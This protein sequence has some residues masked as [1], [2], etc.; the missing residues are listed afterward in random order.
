[1]KT[2]LSALILLVFSANPLIAQ[3]SDLSDLSDYKWQDRV[4]LIF[5]PNTYNSDYRA[6]VDALQNIS[7]G[8]KERD[9]KIFYALEQSSASV[10]GAL[11]SEDAID[12][13]RSDFNISSSDF[14]VLLIGKDGN[15]KYRS[16]EFISSKKLFNEIDS[17]PMRK[18]E[19]GDDGK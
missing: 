11:V 3:N 18:I 15:E 17:M 14:V 4:L 10:K 7:A 8:A 1:M 16:D 5:S 9:L 13:L 19:M 2:L 12:E 6:Q